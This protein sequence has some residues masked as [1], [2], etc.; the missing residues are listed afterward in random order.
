MWCHISCEA[1]GEFWHWSLSGVKG[2]SFCGSR[3]KF[4]LEF[5]QTSSNHLQMGNAT[6][7]FPI[8]SPGYPSWCPLQCIFGTGLLFHW[9]LCI[10]KTSLGHLQ[11]LISCITLFRTFHFTIWNQTSPTHDCRLH[12]LYIAS[13]V[14]RSIPFVLNLYT[15]PGIDSKTWNSHS[16]QRYTKISHENHLL[17]W[18]GRNSS[19]LLLSL[20]AIDQ[21]S[22]P[23][24]SLQA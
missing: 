20:A 12:L 22:H 7:S 2:L 19:T 1:A 6:N 11:K 21:V 5:T 24:Q 13:H 23:T 18:K 9:E 17:L 4:W 3:K 14:L 10:F 15:V 8:S 16:P